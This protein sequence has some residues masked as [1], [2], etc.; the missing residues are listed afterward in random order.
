MLESMRDSQ[1]TIE[2]VLEAA[3]KV[4][5]E[6]GVGRM[7]VEEVARVA[8]ISKGGVLH[9]FPT[10]KSIL[11]ALLQKLIEQFEASIEERSQQDVERVGSFTRA[12]LQ[13]SVRSEARCRDVFLALSAAFRET[14]EMQALMRDAHTR[15]Q[16]R[17]EGDGIDPVRASIVRLAADGLWLSRL[18]GLPIPSE[19]YRDAVIDTLGALTTCTGALFPGAIKAGE[20]PAIV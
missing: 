9:H 8:L 15:L 18:R 13:V 4:I 3:E 11:L 10:K 7:T 17:V 6:Q 20:E 2:A 5:V 1:R 16:G 14:P 12:F 19:Q